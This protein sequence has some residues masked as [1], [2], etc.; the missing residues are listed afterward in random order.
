MPDPTCDQEFFLLTT[1]FYHHWYAVTSS[2]KPVGAT[3]RTRSSH[4][5][6]SQA[7]RPADDGVC[8]LREQYRFT[9]IKHHVFPIDTWS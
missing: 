8:G 6:D 4:S 3:L 7:T 1:C 9:Y 5:E 2:E